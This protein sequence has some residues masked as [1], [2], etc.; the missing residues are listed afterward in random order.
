MKAISIFLSSHETVILAATLLHSLWQG[1]LIAGM[2]YFCLRFI[3]SRLVDLRYYITC[4][5]LVC[6]I[7]FCIA[8]VSF[9][10]LHH[11]PLISHPSMSQAKGVPAQNQTNSIS[12]PIFVA[13]QSYK[14]D[15]ESSSITWEGWLIAFWGIGVYLMVFRL[16]WLLRQDRILIQRCNPIDN[17]EIAAIV[18]ALQKWDEHHPENLSFNK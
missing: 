7:L 8:T 11:Q 5:S 4:G 18:L 3:P 6:F 13:S 9:Q 10:G 1:A 14:P 2:L 17:E 12:E 16:L 15:I